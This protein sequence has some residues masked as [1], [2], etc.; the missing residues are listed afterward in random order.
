ML[1]HLARRSYAVL[2]EELSKYEPARY[3]D[4]AVREAKAVVQL[5]TLVAEVDFSSLDP[6]AVSAMS[7]H[8]RPT[9]TRTADLRPI[10]QAICWRMIVPALLNQAQRL[11]DQGTLQCVSRLA[12]QVSPR[13]R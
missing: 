11:K 12:F 6:F 2:F 10:K 4:L 3:R 8:P 7:P 9:A 13:T 5:I 1:S